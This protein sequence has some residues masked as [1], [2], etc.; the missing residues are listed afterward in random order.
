MPEGPRKRFHPPNNRK[1]S[2]FPTRAFG[3]LFS[4]HLSLLPPEWNSAFHWIPGGRL[5]RQRA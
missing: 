4:H 2:T 5:V 3:S 1:D